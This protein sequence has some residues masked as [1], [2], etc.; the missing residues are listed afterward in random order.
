M[1]LAEFWTEYGGGIIATLATAAA[2]GIVATIK[3]FFARIRKNEGRIT[4]LENDLEA[5]KSGDEE[6]KKYVDI[7]IEKKLKE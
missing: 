5:N 7:M 3:K 6:M 1:T 4:Q 2:L